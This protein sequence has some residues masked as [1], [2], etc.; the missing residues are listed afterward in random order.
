MASRVAGFLV[1]GI[2]FLA[3][4]NARLVAAQERVPVP[5]LTGPVAAPDI[6][7][8]PT[9]NYVFFASNHELAVRGYVEEEFF[10]RGGAR[11]YETPDLKTGAVT[12][13]GH[14]YLTRIVVR[15]PA[16]P[17]RFSGTVLVEW[18]NVTNNFDA[19]NTWFFA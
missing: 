13:S 10:V 19:E 7:G 17:K 1:G 11:T 8:A 3:F 5:D 15:R 4:A 14:P 16:D 12:D 9:H 6:P 18:D 2:V